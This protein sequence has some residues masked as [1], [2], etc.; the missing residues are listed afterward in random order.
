MAL[1][2]LP[3]RTRRWHSDP[4]LSLP[5]D[6]PQLPGPSTC[7]SGARG[8]KLNPDSADGENW[9]LERVSAPVAWG[10]SVGEGSPLI[11]VDDI[12]FHSVAEL[13]PNVSSLS[14]P[15]YGVDPRTHGTQ[16]ASI[17]GARG[18]DTSGMT[19]TMHQNSTAAAIMAAASLV[20]DNVEVISMSEGLYFTNPNNSNPHRPS[21]ENP[22][23]VMLV[24]SVIQVPVT[25]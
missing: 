8:R 7:G 3:D 5:R 6:V 2:Q 14:V 23:D 18:N 19:G 1:G 4:R 24:N 10:C 22:R 20:A 15:N 9:A 25:G 21:M 11:G 12:G 17:I 13:L 16:V